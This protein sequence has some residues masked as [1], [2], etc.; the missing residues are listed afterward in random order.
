MPTVSFDLHQV[1]TALDGPLYRVFQ[2][3]TA[4]VNS[5]KAVF[6]YKT[7]TQ[8]FSHIAT[9]MDMRNWT[10]SYAQAV[11]NEDDYYR[12]EQVT[13]DWSTVALM[14]DDVNMG[15]SRVQLLA[16]ALTDEEG[17]LEIDRTLVLTGG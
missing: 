9:I 17:L 3:L 2:E 5:S 4:A 13:R 6:V 10:D 14:V 8:E 16:S 12:L 7:T 15:V 1:T 11:I